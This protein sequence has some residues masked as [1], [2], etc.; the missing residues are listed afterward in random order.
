MRK[1]L[2]GFFFLSTVVLPA[3]EAQ[4]KLKARFGKGITVVSGDSSF[5]L[6]FGARVQ[7]LYQG[8]LGLETN[9]YTDNL[10]IRRARFKFDGHVFSPA[11]EYKFELGVSNA[12]R[13]N[14]VA[15]QP[16]DLPTFILD[17]YLKWNFADRWSL[18]AGQAKLP[19]NRERIISSQALQFVDRSALNAQFNLDRDLGVQVHYRGKYY[20]FIGSVS[21]GEGRNLTSRNH[22]GYNY[23]MRAEYLPFG[24]FTS[25]GDYFGSD[26]VREQTP[27]LS[28]GVSYDYNDGA[29]RERGQLGD[30]LYVER[31]LKTWFADAH[32]KYR[33]FSSL[34]EYAYR[35]SHDGPAIHDESG[36]FVDAFFTGRGVSLQAGYLFKSDFE[37]A[38]RITDVLPQTE[39][40]RDRNTQFTLCLSHY[41]SGHNLKIQSDVTLIQVD[42]K[43]ESLM[44]RL[45]LDVSF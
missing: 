5:K 17:A 3:A 15:R 38:G 9:E 19:G 18:L 22:G 8:D 21:K 33:G 24:A 20:N 12:D 11:L 39:T 36:K 6:K 37:I 40:Q 28:I 42:Y 27:K 7:T 41:L 13:N 1:T 25:K 45:Q 43:S 2:A 4:H 31:D 34:F 30:F 32:F 44:Y 23:T 10:N 14:G 26:L 16:G 35:L 29:T